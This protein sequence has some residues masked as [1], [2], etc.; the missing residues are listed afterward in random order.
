MARGDKSGYT[1]NQQP[2]TQHI[3]LGHEKRGASRDE[4]EERAWCS[5]NKRDRRGNRT[6]SPHRVGNSAGRSG[7]SGSARNHAGHPRDA[8]W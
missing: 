4:A 5:V 8:G 3:E 1:D 6:G 2:E 7:R